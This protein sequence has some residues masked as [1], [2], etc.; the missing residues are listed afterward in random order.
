L[1]ITE[2]A[3]VVSHGAMPTLPADPIQLGRLFQNLITN[4]L[5]FRRD[6]APRVDIQATLKEEFWEFAIKDNGIGIDPR[7]HERIFVIFQR[8]HGRARPGTGIGLAICRKIV[9]RHGGRIWVESELGAG[10]TFFFT[11]PLR[12]AKSA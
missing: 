10:A 7:H 5:K 6:V 12:K 8:L 1:V 11:L 4:A 2:N 9:E 3:A